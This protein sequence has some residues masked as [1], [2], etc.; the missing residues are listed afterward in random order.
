[1]VGRVEQTSNAAIVSPL[2]PNK[3]YTHLSLSLRRNK[4]TTRTFRDERKF[5]NSFSYTI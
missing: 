4:P 1:M 3:T 5:L 2:S